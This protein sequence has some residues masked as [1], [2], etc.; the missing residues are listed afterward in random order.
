MTDKTPM[1]RCSRGDQCVYPMGCW[2]PASADH[3]SSDKRASD[4]FKSSC[5]ACNREDQ[6]RRRN[7]NPERIREIDRRCYA[8]NNEKRRSDNKRRYHEN[9]DSIREQKHNHYA[10]NS[11]KIR[12]RVRNYRAVNLEKVRERDRLRGRPGRAEYNRQYRAKNATRLRELHRQWYIENYQKVY[13]RARINKQRRRARQRSLPDTFTVA[14]WQ[15]ALDYFGNCCAVC[16]R[17]PDDHV[18][19]AADHWIP[20]SDPRPDNPGSVAANL[21]PLCHG[22]GGCNNRKSSRDPVE[23]LETEFGEQAGKILVRILAYF[24]LVAE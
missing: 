14:D 4:G 18:T 11:E 7:E 16:G 10:E 6:R 23:F 15:R 21:L 5:R 9:R 13:D 24:Q 17:A 1:K 12:E 3:F 20:L 2:Q 8:K 22:V 19:L